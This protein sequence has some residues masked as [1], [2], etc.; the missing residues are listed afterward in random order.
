[1][2]A[3]KKQQSF[4][5]LSQPIKAV[6]GGLLV[7]LLAAAFYF[8]LFAPLGEDL[9]AAETKNAELVAKKQKIQQRVIDYQQCAEELSTLEQQT[10]KNKRVLPERAE[11]PAFLQDL[12]RLAELSG[13]EIQLV[14]P[15]PEEAEEHYT[16]IPVKLSLQGRFHQ[17]AKFFFNVSRIDRAISME[18][19]GLRPLVNRDTDAADDGVKLDV[20]VLA[21]T[22]RK[23][24]PETPGKPPAGSAAK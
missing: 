6:L 3:A 21:T 11:I 10:R 2:A 18:N 8:L 12:N 7:I 13:L 15:T 17:L 19:I 20:S 4:E 22:Y 23:P 5:T 16:R 1:M 14:E 9:Q 24:K